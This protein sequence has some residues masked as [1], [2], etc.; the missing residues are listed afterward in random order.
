MYNV[1]PKMEKLTLTEAARVLGISEGAVRKRYKRGK[2]RGDTG[3]DGRLYVWVDTGHTDHPEPSGELV[4][5]LRD[6]VRSLERQLDQER[7]AHAES[8]RIAAIL[9]QRVP[10]LEAPSE[11]TRPQEGPEPRSEGYGTPENS[12]ANI[13]RP[14]YRRIFGG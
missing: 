5:E 9:A 6:R 3:V 10:E 14:W 4:E 7:Q 8:R 12:E 13:G 2:L 11:A 1:N